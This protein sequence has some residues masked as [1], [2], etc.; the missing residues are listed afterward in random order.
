MEYSA[1]SALLLCA[2]QKLMELKTTQFFCKLTSK[3][4]FK[5]ETSKFTQSTKFRDI[6]VPGHN[7]DTRPCT[8]HSTVSRNRHGQCLLCGT[9]RISG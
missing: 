1:Q 3:L 5:R 8:L 2:E 4:Y 6:S 9:K 7:P